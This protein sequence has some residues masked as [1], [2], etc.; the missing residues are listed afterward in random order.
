M[1]Y[2]IIVC[3]P[4]GLWQWCVVF[5]AW[6]PW[7]R[8]KCS[9]RW[10][11]DWPKAMARDGVFWP[12][13]EGCSPNLYYGSQWLWWSQWV[14]GQ[15]PDARHP[16]FWDSSWRVSFIVHT[17]KEFWRLSLWAGSKRYLK[18]LSPG[19]ARP[20]YD[21]FNNG[22]YAGWSITTT[23]LSTVSCGFIC[24]GLDKRLRQQLTDKTES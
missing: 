24:N 10:Q 3:Y 9:N 21:G 7:A 19:C 16:V 1:A 4:P 13:L 12:P 18:Q 2:D 17:L 14:A 5:Q 8:A 20:A 11:D 15:L 6:S 23:T 22:L